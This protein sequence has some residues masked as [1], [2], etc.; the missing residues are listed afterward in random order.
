MAV[1]TEH[2]PEQAVVPAKEVEEVEEVEEIEE[3]EEEETGRK[4]TIDDVKTHPFDARFPNTNQTYN[5]YQ[6]Y[7]DYF[8]CVESKGEDFAP[9]KSFKFAYQSLC[10]TLWTDQ[11][12]EQREEG[13]F[14]GLVDQSSNEHH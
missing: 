7:V 6:N 10:P 4:I 3:V 5:C 11:W 1:E 14:T 12:D 2:K 13:V 8:K 9:C